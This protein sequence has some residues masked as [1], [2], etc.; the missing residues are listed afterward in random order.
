LSQDEKSVTV[1]TGS[2]DDQKLYTPK[3][4]DNSLNRPST[5]AQA[6]IKLTDH[7]LA[8]QPSCG[9]KGDTEKTVSVNSGEQNIVHKVNFFSFLCASVILYI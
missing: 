7:F 9:I 8:S 6:G 3:H 4:K 5:A 1:E 2:D